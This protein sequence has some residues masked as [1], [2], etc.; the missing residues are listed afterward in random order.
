[1]LR[2]LESLLAAARIELTDQQKQQLLGYIALLH[3][4][5]QVYNLTSVNDP[6]Q[7]LT[8][9]ILDS[10]VVNIHLKGKRFIDIGTGPGLPGVP[11]AIVRPESEF[12]L[13]DSSGKRVRFLR[14]VQYELKLKNIIP[15]QSRVEDY[16]SD[17]DGVISRAFASLQD[18]VSLCRH[19]ITKPQC[20]FYALKGVRPDDE[21]VVLPEEIRLDKII[22]L[23]V[24]GLNA[25]RHLVI[26]EYP[27]SVTTEKIPTC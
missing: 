18:M 26:L 23:H 1:M 3:K 22:R 6:Q 25:E 9:H 13:L 4:W 5:N 15:V 20:C 14:Q 2:R 10:I 8:R 24:P 27:A 21:L 11:L 17:F 12:T 16:V 7:M 19:L